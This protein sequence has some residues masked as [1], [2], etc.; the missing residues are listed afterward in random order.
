ME[1]K[2]LLFPLKRCP[3]SQFILIKSSHLDV[4]KMIVFFEAT[5][6]RK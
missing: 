1:R 6:D 5:N 3:E 4:K 2:I